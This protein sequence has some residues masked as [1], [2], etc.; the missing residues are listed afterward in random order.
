MDAAKEWGLAEPSFSNGAAYADL[1]RDGDLDLIV[2]NENQE[3]F[4]YRNRSREQTGNS[5]IGVHLRSAAPNLFAIGSKIQVYK[6]GQ[7]FYREM[8]PSRGFQ[9]SV[10]YTQII[11]Q[12]G[13]EQSAL[14]TTAGA[15]RHFLLHR[16]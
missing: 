3:A 11:G 9:S 5:F 13:T 16:K 8:I 12:A 6:A 2:N 14:C 10:D 7:V 4:V 1:D 15:K